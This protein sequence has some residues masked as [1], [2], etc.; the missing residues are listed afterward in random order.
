MGAIEMEEGEVGY[1]N[2]I[3]TNWICFDHQQPHFI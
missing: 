2:R 3:G 1:K